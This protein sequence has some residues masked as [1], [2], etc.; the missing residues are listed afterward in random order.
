MK[1]QKFKKLLDIWHA[2]SLRKSHAHASLAAK[3]RLY[4]NII[5]TPSVIL[6]T[7]VGTAVFIEL[8]EDTDSPDAV[9]II[10]IAM[11]LTSASLTALQS[12]FNF[13]EREQLHKLAEKKYARTRRHISYLTYKPSDIS[14][15]D[16]SEI[17]KML[18]EANETEPSIPDTIWNKMLDL[19][20]LP[21]RDEY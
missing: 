16:I 10:I 2:H 4:R 12:F 5:G 15:R 1:E 14:D 11:V 8:Q 19:Y 18:N 13:G 20:K 17:E 6:S 7:I 9:K 3:S 21:L